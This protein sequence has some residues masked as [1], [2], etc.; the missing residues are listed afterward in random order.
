M[1]HTVCGRRVMRER[2]E[3]MEAAAPGSARISLRGLARGRSRLEA[4]RL[5]YTVC[6]ECTLCRPPSSFRRTSDASHGMLTVSVSAGPRGC[7]DSD[8]GH[9]CDVYDS[10]K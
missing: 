1:V 4:A 7:L 8:D 10:D 9:V 2:F 5:F 3:G 6:S